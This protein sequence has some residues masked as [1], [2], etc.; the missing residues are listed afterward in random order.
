MH[1]SSRAYRAIH[2]VPAILVSLRILSLT[3]MADMTPQ[4]LE[5]D[6]TPLPTRQDFVSQ[7]SLTSSYQARMAHIKTPRTTRRQRPPSSNAHDYDAQIDDQPSFATLVATWN[8]APVPRPWD[9]SAHH[10]FPSACS[11][12]GTSIYSACTVQCTCV[13][14]HEGIPMQM[15]CESYRFGR[16]KG[17]FA[18]SSSHKRYA[19]TCQS[20][21]QNSHRCTAEN[22]LL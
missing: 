10:D 17:P 9:Q 2:R 21:V 22:L 12:K 15:G 18:G 1:L 4:H 13:E 16:A 19:E 6:G 20:T 3:H 8:P 7:G 5:P 11:G 14:C